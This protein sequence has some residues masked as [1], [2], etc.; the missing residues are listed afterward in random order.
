[1]GLGVF[2]EVKKTRAATK[3]LMD[4]NK[5]DF[6]SPQEIKVCESVVK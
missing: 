6:F 3:S 5:Q 1:M 2:Q 4:H